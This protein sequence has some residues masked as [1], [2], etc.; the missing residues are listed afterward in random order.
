MKS[1]FLTLGRILALVL[2]SIGIVTPYAAVGS[3]LT[4]PHGTLNAQLGWS[5]PPPLSTGWLAIPAPP[6]MAFKVNIGATLG[7]TFAS[8]SMDGSGILNYSQYPGSGSLS[9]ANTSGT[10]KAK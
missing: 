3:Q 2:F 9:F 1:T 10:R 5:S 4:Q 8:V 7:L 6:G